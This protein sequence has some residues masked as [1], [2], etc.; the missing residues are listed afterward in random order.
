MTPQDVK[1]KI[2]DKK[3][4]LAD[5]GNYKIQAKLRMQLEILKLQLDIA[6]L[7]EK[8]KKLKGTVINKS[9][10]TTLF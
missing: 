2:K 8:M 3:N 9:D 1:N 7:R 5:T 6:E 10:K 4:V